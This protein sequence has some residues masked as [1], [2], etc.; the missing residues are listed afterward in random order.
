M[1]TR[2][3]VKNFALISSLELDFSNNL[4]ILSGET[5]AGKSIIVDCIMLLRGG[6]YDKSMLRYGESSGFVEGVFS[7][8]SYNK[9]L[10]ADYIDEDDDQIIITRK[11]SA[12]GRNDV[13][14]NGR[15]ATI[16]MLKQISCDLIDVCGQNEHQTLAN[17]SNH[18]KIVDYY[19]RHSTDKILE[20]LAIKY[21]ELKEINTKL[22]EIGNAATRA[23]NLDLY[24]FQLD[25]INAAKLVKGEED[26]LTALRKRYLGAERICT[27]LSSVLSFLS[28]NDD[29]RIAL[30]LLYDAK[31]EMDSIVSYDKSYLSLSERI[32]AAII[33]L[34]DI[35]ETVSDELSTFDFSHG[36]LEETEKRLNEIR[37]IFRKYGDYESVM[38]YK[39]E[40]ETKIDEI[41]NA[42]SFYDKLLTS[43]AECLKSAYTLAVELSDA[44]RDAAAKL[45]TLVM[46][47]LNELGMEQAVFSV[48]FSDIPKLSECE[49]SLSA[50]GFDKVEFYLC[51]NAGQPLQPLVKI[52]S[53][54]E[55]SRLMLA[56]K[57]VSSN[58]DE[59]PTVIFDEIDTGISGKVGQEIAKKLARLSKSKQLLCVT[60]LPQIASM[61]DT[62]FFISK[63]ISDMKTFTDVK[64]LSD[65]EQVDEIARLSGGK[66][67]SSEAESNALLMKKWS[68]EYKKSLN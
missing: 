22:S 62:H 13:R 52:I 30:D 43:K 45:E 15:S 39:T 61:A 14:I 31:S 55:L 20:R 66:D 4:N 8:D 16:S 19:A 49:H 42:D 54:G 32:N 24:K 1:L 5:G 46:N 44:R 27:A 40:L 59:T 50:N 10:F 47:E 68:V 36:E 33:E 64:L 29:E 53:G 60:H 56:L 57:V 67:I 58:I 48:S 3:T 35:A 38:A 34:E 51:A 2:L 11:F 63:S 65:E 7:L 26:E 9:E 17:V 25:E 23:R 37:N 28:E 18:I 12:D 41:E 6:R 21:A